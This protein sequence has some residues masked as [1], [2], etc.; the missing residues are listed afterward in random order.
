MTP[1]ECGHIDRHLKRK[2]Y[3]FWRFMNIYYQSGGRIIELLRVQAKHVNIEKQEYKATIIKGNNRRE[4][5]R[6]INNEILPLWQ[7]VLELSSNKEDFIFSEGLIPGER[8]VGRAGITRRWEIHV[9]EELDITADFSSL[10][11]LFLDRADQKYG[12]DMPQGLADH[13][14]PIVTMKHYATGHSSRELE[15][16]KNVKILFAGSA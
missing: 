12:I 13:T 6:A 1:E 11:N 8:Q 5:I 3:E 16:K 2:V 14:T 9:K 15:K 10:K 4:V 7:E